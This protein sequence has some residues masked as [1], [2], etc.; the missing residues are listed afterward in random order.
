MTSCELIEKYLLVRGFD[1]KD[2]AN[3]VTSLPLAFQS[4]GRNFAAVARSASF[5]GL[6][7]ASEL[8]FTDPFVGI[9][10]PPLE[11]GGADDVEDELPD[12]R[13]AKKASAAAWHSS[14][15]S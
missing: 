5:I 12:P 8:A 14:S 6:L 13:V 15:E 4:A 2:V 7:L 10:V 3:F 9:G 1:A 11:L